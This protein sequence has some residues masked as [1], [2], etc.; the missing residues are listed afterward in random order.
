MYQDYREMLDQEKLD[1]VIVATPE[2]GGALPCIHAVQAGL[3]LYAE[4]PLTA[5]V[6]EGRMLVNAVRKHK[7]I[8]QVGTQQRTMELNQFCCEFVRDGKIGKL[9]HVLAVNWPGPQPIISLPEEPIPEGDRWD[10]WCGPTALRPFN[11]KLQFQW[12]QWRDYSGGDMTNFKRMESIK[13]SGHLARAL[14]PV[15]N[16]A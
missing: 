11:S 2:H 7:R 6:Q 16:L 10:A 3:D 1:A 5:Y 14:P 12:M 13:F 8:C 15:R 4:K 9:K